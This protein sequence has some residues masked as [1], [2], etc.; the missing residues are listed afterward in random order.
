MSNMEQILDH[1]DQQCK[2]KGVRLTEKRKRVLSGLLASEK[3]LS[4]YEL[5]DYCQKASGENIPV[6]SVYRILDFLQVEHLVHKLHT[7]NKYVAC[8]HITCSHKH[9]VPQFLICGQ[10]N[11]VTE[12]GIGQTFVDKLKQNIQEA[13]FHLMS[14]Q[15][16]MDC[17][18][19]ACH[20]VSRA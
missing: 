19:N 17:L 16:E 13:G 1:A 12:V 5:A 4:A 9:E 8:S 6:M 2:T 18:C 15:F 3:A 11:R 7:T 14:P 20:S 10:C